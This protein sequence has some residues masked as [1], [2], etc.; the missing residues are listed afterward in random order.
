MTF[1][2]QLPVSSSVPDAIRWLAGSMTTNR[3][4]CNTLIFTAPNINSFSAPLRKL[5][6]FELIVFERG[7]YEVQQ[8]KY[9]KNFRDPMKDKVLAEFI[10][11][12]REFAFEQLPSSVQKR[13]DDWRAVQKAEGTLPMA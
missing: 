2:R 6:V 3:P 10:E 5:V 13:Y 9:R 11:G 8:I 4:E 12:N 7:K 1:K